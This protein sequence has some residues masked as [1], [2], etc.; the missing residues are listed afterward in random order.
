M[1]VGMVG[2][3]LG[4]SWLELPSK[5]RGSTARTVHWYNKHGQL[6]EQIRLNAAVAYPVH[7]IVQ[8]L[9]I[10]TPTEVHEHLSEIKPSQAR[11]G[12]LG[13]LATESDLQARKR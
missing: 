6:V 1:L 3:M 13:Q 8:C 5:Q 2:E 4:P 7:T 11:S 9:A 12:A 10:P